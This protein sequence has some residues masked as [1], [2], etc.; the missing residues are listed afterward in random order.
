MTV[1]IIED[2]IKILECR[3]SLSDLATLI[4]LKHA[5]HRIFEVL[6]F[7]L[8]DL[9]VVGLVAEASFQ[10]AECFQDLINLTLFV[11]DT[12]GQFIQRLYS[13]IDKLVLGVLEVVELTFE[14]IS[15][16]LSKL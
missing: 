4:L 10:I 3:V 14:L 16:G 1:E 7:V 5:S 8:L 13:D 15:L 12:V 2:V 9:Q 6:D 11:N